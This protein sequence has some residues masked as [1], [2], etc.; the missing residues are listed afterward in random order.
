MWRLAVSE[1]GG[2]RVNDDVGVMLGAHQRGA[3]LQ[4]LPPGPGRTDQDS[5]SPHPV[6]RLF[7]LS[8][9]TELDADEQ[10]FYRSLFGWAFQL[11]L[12]IALVTAALH[13]LNGGIQELI[14]QDRMLR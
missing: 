9:R 3:D 10:P 1:R 11:F 12:V 13:Y 5:S 14:D 8:G 6:Y 7:G 4:N 2:E